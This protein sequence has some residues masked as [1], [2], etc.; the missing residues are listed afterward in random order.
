MRSV[1]RLLIRVEVNL[2]PAFWTAV[3]LAQGGQIGYGFAAV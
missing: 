1:D 2:S 3:A